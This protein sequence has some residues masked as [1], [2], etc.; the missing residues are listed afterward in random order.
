CQV[1][2]VKNKNV[3]KRLEPCILRDLSRLIF[4]DNGNCY[5]NKYIHQSIVSVLDMNHRYSN[6]IFHI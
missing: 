3:T 6:D 2:S 5:K 4:S 1:D